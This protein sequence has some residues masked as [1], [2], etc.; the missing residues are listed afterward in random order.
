LPT[1]AGWKGLLVSKWMAA[2]IRSKVNSLYSNTK[3]KRKEEK[4]TRYGEGRG[5]PKRELKCQ[6]QKEIPATQTFQLPYCR[7]TKGVCQLDA[8]GGNGRPERMR[9]GATWR[10]NTGQAGPEFVRSERN[11]GQSLIAAQEIL[12][13][14]KKRHRERGGKCRETTESEFRAVWFC[15]EATGIKGRRSTEIPALQRG[16]K[17]RH[18]PLSQK[19]KKKE[20][21]ER[22]E[23]LRR[24]ATPLY[25]VHRRRGR[26]DQRKKNS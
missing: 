20:I 15:A 5:A 2:G 18:E 14:G 24:A 8:G 25:N 10:P 9:G 7:G 22:K 13:K 17:R 16:G 12:F 21:A 1:L 19:K 3:T 4:A 23:F 6:N 26:N 11:A